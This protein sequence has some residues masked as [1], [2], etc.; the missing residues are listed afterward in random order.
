MLGSEHELHERAEEGWDIFAGHTPHRPYVDAVKIRCT[1][2]GNLVERIK[3]VGNP[4]LDAG[5]VPFSTLDYRNDRDYWREW[6]PADFITESFPGQFRNWFYSMLVMAT[7]LENK[8]P[9]KTVLGFASVMAYDGSL[10]SKSKG[11]AVWFAEAVE[12]LGADTMRWLYASQP[13]EQDVWFQTIPTAEQME[14]AAATGMPVRLNDEWLR[15]RSTLDKL[16]NVYYFFVTYANIDRFDPA[17]HSLPALERSAIDRWLLS[18][19]QEVVRTATDGLDR[20]DAAQAASAISEFIDQMSN[21]YIRRVRRQFWKSE[22]DD[23]KIG[24]YLTLYEALVTLTKLLAPITPF[25]A[26]AMYTNLVRAGDSVAPSSVH[27]VDWPVVDQTLINPDL[28]AETRLIQRVVNLGRSAREQ[29]KIRV[30]QPLGTIYV[31]VPDADQERLIR[32]GY[33]A[34]EE[35][36]V[37]A[38]RPLAA[39]SDMLRTI[40]TPKM[41]VLGQR[42]RAKMQAILAGIKSLSQE[43]KEAFRESGTLALRLADNDLVT[44]TTEEAEVHAG[45]RDGFIASEDHGVVVVLDTTITPELEA[46]GFVRDVTHQINTIRKKAGFAIEENIDTTLVTDAGLAAVIERF[47]ADVRDETLTRTLTILRAEDHPVT[48]FAPDVFVEEIPDGKLGGHAVTVAITR[49]TKTTSKARSTT[50]RGGGQNGN[51]SDN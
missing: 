12:R 16:W 19:L 49:A 42:Y 47:A 11:T 22:L 35:L 45:A 8:R 26:E 38:L 43:A 46:E 33:Q 51:G 6:F 36:N 5:I 7:V 27:L 29:A 41:S 24:A 3:D 31:R 10:M 32:L 34:L 2:C 9:F 50:K 40:V 30:R 1:K 15:I 48:E 39:E 18:E 4:W 14:A 28:E 17:A 25:L 13:P 20:F 37:K 44:L 23:E 21:W